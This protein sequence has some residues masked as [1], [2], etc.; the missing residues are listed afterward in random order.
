MLTMMPHLRGVIVR[1]NGQLESAPPGKT[2]M[3]DLGLARES[4]PV[5]LGDVF[6]A[7]YRDG[8]S[9]HRRIY[10][11][12]EKDGSAIEYANPAQ[13][14]TQVDSRA[15]FSEKPDPIRFYGRRV[16]QN[17]DRCLGRSRR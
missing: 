5:D 15:Q 7:Y 9:Q 13:S 11:V 14:I 16:R 8:H 4:H 3:I 12:T 10:R 6:M 1:Q 17:K 2:R